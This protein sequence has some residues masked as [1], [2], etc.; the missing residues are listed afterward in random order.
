MK[1]NLIEK[2]VLTINRFSFVGREHGLRRKK[3][4]KSQQK[5]HQSNVRLSMFHK[6]KVKESCQALK[7]TFY[8]DSQGFGFV[9]C[10]ENPNL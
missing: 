3:K 8:V 9:V 4:K 1:I 2:T 6:T 5:I 7:N 10:S